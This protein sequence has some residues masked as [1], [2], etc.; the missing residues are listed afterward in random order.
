MPLCPDQPSQQVF[1]PTAYLCAMLCCAVLRCTMLR[2]P[3]GLQAAVG[4]SAGHVFGTHTAS[5]THSELPARLWAHCLVM[6]NV[7]ISLPTHT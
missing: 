5:S 6:R 3:V 1:H 7:K 2:I 4:A